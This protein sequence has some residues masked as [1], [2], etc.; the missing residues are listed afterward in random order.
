MLPVKIRVVRNRHGSAMAG[1]QAWRFRTSDKGL[2]GNPISLGPEKIHV[3]GLNLKSKNCID[4]EFLKD[5]IVVMKRFPRDSSI[6]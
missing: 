2:W 4:V 5:Q 6:R 3:Y 1:W